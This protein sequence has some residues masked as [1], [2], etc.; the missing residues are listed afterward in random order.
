MRCPH[1]GGLNPEN[2]HYCVRCGREVTQLPARSPA[3]PPQQ[4]PGNP[5][6]SNPRPAPPVQRTSYPPAVNPRPPMPQSAPPA[7]PPPAPLAA[8]RR[9]KVQVAP[10]AQPVLAPAPEAPAPFPPRTVA[11]LEQLEQGALPYT[12]V[13]DSASYG[14]KK[15]VRI[16]YQRSSPWQQVATLWKALQEYNEERFDTIIIQGV[17][18]QRADTYEYTNGQLVFDR[19]VRLGSQTLNLYQIETDN[20]FSNASIRIVLTE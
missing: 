3:Q 11:Q 8:P 9:S 17:Q 15:I 16:A 13:N 14:K 1:C 5:P 19:N 7:T 4:R 10:V 12:F 6:P 20:G 2:T 18:N